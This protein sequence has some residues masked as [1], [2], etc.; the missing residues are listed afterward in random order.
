MPKHTIAYIGKTETCE[1]TARDWDVLEDI[2]EAYDYENG[3]MLLSKLSRCGMSYVKKWP[4]ESFRF[5]ID[6][7]ISRYNWHI[8]RSPNRRKDTNANLPERD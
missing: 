6:R 8:S 7:A 2:A 3:I 5:W 4:L 1:V